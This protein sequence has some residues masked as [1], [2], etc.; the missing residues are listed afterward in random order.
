MSFRERDYDR[1]DRLERKLEEISGAVHKIERMERQMSAQLDKLQVTVRD[2]EAIEDSA[3]TLIVGLATA[4]AAVKDDP[5]K[6]QALAD[7]LRAKSDSL[8]AS[9]AANQ[10]PPPGP[11]PPTPEQIAAARQA[12]ADA[13]AAT[14]QAQ[15]DFD[16]SGSQSDSDKLDAAKA[17]EAKANAALAALLAA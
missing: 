13:H 14:V 7:E 3:V 9:V 12:V 5:A 16:L 10:I 1:S 6:I 15:A 4:I 8:A 17:A 11:V 2:T